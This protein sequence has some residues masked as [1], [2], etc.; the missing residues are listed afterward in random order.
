MC[1]PSTVDLTA[2]S[3]TTGSTPGLTFTYYTDA[4]ATN[5][6]ANPNAVATSGTYYIKGTTASGCFDIKPVTVTINPA[7]TPSVSGNTPVC[8]SFNGNTES[9]STPDVAGHTYNWT[10]VGGNI[11]SGQG[12]HQITVQWTTPGSGSV[13]VTETITASG[14]SKSDSK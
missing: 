9:Y 13:S 1:E 7:P 4:A 5:V 2:N 14:C 12:T 8:E 11:A 6:L 3:V 10:V